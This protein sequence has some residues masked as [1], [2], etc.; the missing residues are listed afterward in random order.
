M[1]R[2]ELTYQ[3]LGPSGQG[4]LFVSAMIAIASLPANFCR[5]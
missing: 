1:M 2:Q 3:L 5:C 4:T